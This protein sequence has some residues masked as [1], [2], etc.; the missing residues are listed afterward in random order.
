MEC[1]SELEPCG[2]SCFD[3]LSP[4]CHAVVR[5]IHELTLDEHAYT[6]YVVAS[7]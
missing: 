2:A 6:P 4:V 5:N 3:W 1:V 7:S